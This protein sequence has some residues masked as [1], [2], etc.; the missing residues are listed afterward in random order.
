MEVPGD[1]ERAQAPLAEAEA[2]FL[3]LGP[4]GFPAGNY[5]H[6]KAQFGS[7][8]AELAI[9]QGDFLEAKVQARESLRFF[10]QLGG[11]G[12]IHWPLAC[13][14]TACLNLGEYEQAREHFREARSL[15]VEF[16][17]WQQ[18]DDLRWLGVVDFRQGNLDRAF[19]YCQQSLREAIE[20]P[21]NNVV[22]SCLALAAGIAAKIGQPARA[23][24][25]SGAAQALYAKQGRKA[26]EDSSLD[27]L[28]LGWREGPDQEAILSAF[29][30]GRNMNAEQATAF[31]LGDTTD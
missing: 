1:S 27:T 12:N 20:L 10:E 2:I 14:G 17:G 24:S 4:D 3:E 9:S 30:A 7:M 29:E 18:A 5:L 19:E 11:R 13:L 21:D 22:A 6:L 8:K 16:E 25:L 23:A 28:L 31:A 15:S 26:W